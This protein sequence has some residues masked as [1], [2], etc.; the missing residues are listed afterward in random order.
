LNQAERGLS[1]NRNRWGY[2]KGK[3]RRC[4]M[5]NRAGPEADMRA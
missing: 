5:N 1:L 3:Q 2:G 4:D